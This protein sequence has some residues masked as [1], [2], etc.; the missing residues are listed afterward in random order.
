MRKKRILA[1]LLSSAIAFSGM[2]GNVFAAEE[3]TQEEEF[4]GD[5]DVTEDIAEEPTEDVGESVLESDQ[6]AEEFAGFS[7]GEG[8]DF[9]TED[10]EINPEVEVF[11]DGESAGT[12]NTG[13]S[14]IKWEI[15]DSNDDGM[16][17]TLVISGNGDME[18]YD[19]AK[20]TPW[21]PYANNI[22][23]IIIENGVT[24]VGMCS[25]KDFK[26][27]ENISFGNSVKII[28]Q[29]AFEN[30]VSIKTITIPDGVIKIEGDSFGGC[31]SLEKIVIPDTVTDI[32]MRAFYDC[33][34]LTYVK[35]SKNL[36]N[37]GERAF[38]NCSG[39]KN[40]YLPLT[41][42]KIGKRCFFRYISNTELIYID[43]IH[44]NGTLGD[45]EKIEGSNDADRWGGLAG[46]VHYIAHHAEKSA[47]CLKSGFEEYW[48]C[49]SCGGKAYADEMCTQKLDS[50]PVIPALG[51]D[52][53]DG[54]ITKAP[55]CIAE[56]VMTYSCK[57]E[58][59]DYTETKSVP[60]SQVHVYS[61]ATYE[62][63]KDNLQ[64]TATE[65]CSLC[66]YE[67]IETVDSKMKVIEEATCTKN[68]TA[69][70][71]A[72]FENADFQSKT[73]EDIIPMLDHNNTEIKYRK[74]ASCEEDGYTGDTYC[75]DCGKYLESGEVIEARGHKWNSGA[76]KKQPTC[77][78]EGEKVYTC[79]RCDKVK[80]EKIPSIGHNWDNGKITREAT[81][82]TVGE[83]TYTCLS[84]KITKTEKVPLTGHI[85]TIDPAVE[86]TCTT[87][88]K[89]EGSHCS[90][91]NTVLQPQKTISALG[92][93]WD[94]GKITKEATCVENGEKV[95]TCIRCN[96]TQNQIIE[97]FGHKEVKD[98]AVAATCENAGKSEGSHCSICGKILEKQD[99]IPALGHK[100]VEDK[101][102]DST[103]D[104]TGKTEGVH[105]D[106][107]GKVFV[108]QKIIP[109]KNHTLKTV[110]TKNATCEEAGS[111]MEYCLTCKK[112]INPFLVIP[113]VGHKVVE[114][115][116]IA[117]TCDKAGKTEGSHCSVCGK[118]LVVQ[119]VI[120]AVGHSWNN[121]KTIKTASISEEGLQQRAC[122]NCG[123]IENKN[124]PKLVPAPTA[125]PTTTP[126]IPETLT[127]KKSKT[128][129][130][131]PASSWK[132]V[133][134]S[135]SN[136]KVAT[137]DKKGKVKA[138]S[139]GTAKITV[140]S[141]SKKAICIVT[142]PG[143]TAI[144]GIKSTISVKRGKTYTLKPKLSY[145]GKA[146]RVTYK[147]SN[148]K[149]ATVSKKGVI[150][151]KKKG[152]AT[153]TIKSG[154]VT[155][156]C[157]VKVK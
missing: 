21:Y 39:L 7:D 46:Y 107:C 139:V 11:T 77:T 133:K 141:G 144:K 136:K 94:D 118:I 111:G 86:A 27:L 57:R 135:T 145:A 70:Y 123:K 85:E 3:F 125:T 116:K 66:E 50:I 100:V 114:D 87:T 1:V 12:E 54:V 151:G 150:K 67:N 75:K 142:V 126:V 74:E 41:L 82:V 127:L 4:F 65:A 71:V 59:C 13:Q 117:P 110:V 98:E 146:D 97:K 143:T 56:G 28:G 61:Q 63:S 153:I 44:Y 69:Q 157:K 84:C 147:S 96:E 51:H 33:K 79:F 47:T 29:D 140:K 8:E 88:G 115:K 40:I 154:K 81:C 95:Y 137:V 149:I 122:N 2:P 92:H 148:K 152:T 18:K 16:D 72:D 106:L 15:V 55:T 80:I 113:A 130:L 60:K 35:M 105:C 38:Y 23:S 109:T 43:A 31:S 91:C 103:C 10:D 26:N 62:W 156:K 58:G 14:N 37:L 93:S 20:Y 89:T 112:V 99:E 155:K 19:G 129:T 90:V 45:W 128:S 52:L 102:Y 101:G 78:E 53:D 104:K 131:K 30:C 138:V 24:S 32:G 121:W 9:V 108:E 42:E 76:V 68:G 17:D 6:G 25:F 132:N 34:K 120:S 5:E 36:V 119:N 73:K 49:N 83:R 48:S 64:C 134:Y 22:S 124:I